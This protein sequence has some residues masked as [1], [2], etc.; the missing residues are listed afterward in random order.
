MISMAEIVKT[1]I[2][3]K[4]LVDSIISRDRL[5]ALI[6]NN[7]NKNIILIISPAGFG[8]T[9]LVL[10]FFK[11]TGKKY[12]WLYL[13]PDVNSLRSFMEYMVHSI[14]ELN[15]NFGVKTLELL[16]SMVESQVIS[17]DEANSI[18]ALT[19]TFSN[20][21]MNCFDEDVYLVID[22]LHNA[23]GKTW[24]TSTFNSLIEDFPPNLHIFITSRALPDFN[25][26]RLAAKRNLLKIDTG[27][28][29]FNLDETEKLLKELKRALS[30]S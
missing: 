3:P 6:N 22:D 18:S 24:L 4:K 29:V 15:K 9:T 10:D 30:K 27:D 2:T 12:A 13:A 5:I 11:Q 20:E 14:K 25:F 17:S 1:R 16:D 26:P 8:K 21:F 28:M 7:L 19:G 23:G